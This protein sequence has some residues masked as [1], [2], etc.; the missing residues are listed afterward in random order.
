MA[1]E[2]K[3]AT[4]P[5]A[6][7]GLPVHVSAAPD[8]PVPP[9]MASVTFE[10]FEVTTSPDESSIVTWGWVGKARPPVELLGSCVK[11]SFEAV[12][13]TVN[14]PLVALV[15]FVAEAVRE[16]EPCVPSVILH[17]AKVATPPVA[18]SG[19]ELQAS[20]PDPELT[21][22]LM[23]LVAPVTT[24]P[25]ESST[26][27]TGWVGKAEPL[28]DA[29]GE[30]PK[31]SC[32]APPA[33]VNDVLVPGVSA[34]EVSVAVRLK[35]PCVPSV[36]VQPVNVATPL[37]VVAERVVPPRRPPLQLRVPFPELMASVMVSLWLLVTTLPPASSTATTG[38]VPNAMPPVDAPGD[39]VKATCA[40][41]PTLMLKAALVALNAPSVAVSV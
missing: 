24:S 22:R 36:M 2:L 15:R 26:Q 7:S 21:A 29:V 16:K 17:P 31:T 18:V 12:P 11:T 32:V 38:C 14:D 4:P 13:A 41:G 9:V 25:E 3:V 10:V 6:A 33:T 40:A 5:V 34:C 30:T 39:V 19:F 35:T 8:V 23:E 20:V 28:L 27:T 1:H 37:R